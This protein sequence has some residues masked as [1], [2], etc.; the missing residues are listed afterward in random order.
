MEKSKKKGIIIGIVSL[1]VVTLTLL[2]LTYAYYRTRIID[3]PN[4]KSISVT[5]RKLELTYVNGNEI[6]NSTLLPG[7]EIVKTFTVE[8]TGDDVIEYGVYLENVVNEFVNIEDLS[9]NITC[10][11][12]N[13]NGEVSGSCNGVSDYQYPLTN[14][15]LITNSI[16]KKIIHKYTL[17]L[18]YANSKY[19]QADDMDKILSGVI[20]I[21]ATNDVYELLIDANQLNSTDVVEL[22]S[23]P[24]SARQI[25]GVYK[26]VG[27]ELGE[28]N[29]IIKD[30]DGNTK[31]ETTLQIVKGDTQNVSGNIVSVTEDTLRLRMSIGEINNNKITLNELEP[32]SY[33]V[34]ELNGTKYPVEQF[35]EALIASTEENPAKLIGTAVLNKTILL[36]E[37]DKDMYLN[38]GGYTLMCE[39]GCGN[40]IRLQGN[41]S[42]LTISNGQIKALDG[43][44]PLAVGYIT[45][46]EQNLNLV[47]KND[48]IINAMSYGI[49]VYG[50]NAKL[51]FYGKLYVS[52]NG[53]AIFGNGTSAGETINVY[54]GAVISAVGNGGIALYLPNLGVT[55]INGGTITGE[56][57]IS[58]KAGELNVNKGTLVSTGE[59]AELEA[60]CKGNGSSNAGDVIFAEVNEGYKRNIKI[61]ISEN[62]NLTSNKANIIRVRK[63]ELSD[64]NDT[65]NVVTVTGK[66]TT[67]V[68]DPLNA[69]VITYN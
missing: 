6:V 3:N 33:Y 4:D 11:S 21:Y 38:L 69:N 53:Y 27:V 40:L 34:V 59:K 29:L 20:K 25:N 9:I 31:G 36:E 18:N 28:H 66:Y 7:D 14:E 48:V 24:K 63:C 47:V 60:V 46:D 16:D 64:E 26:M 55:T 51:D 32:E 2:G 67:A 10:Q 1:F 37:T 54:D 65:A 12:V 49:G 56:T 52:D 30:K 68:A 13:Q 43:V 42:S 23:N 22:H 35:S 17:T 58:M 41:N 5:S 15:Q 57:A 50:N 39:S 8:N 44:V 19:N 45:E 62:A 61:N